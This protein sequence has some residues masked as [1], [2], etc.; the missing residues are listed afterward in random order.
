MFV[1]FIVPV[2][3]PDTEAF[4]KC[5]KGL[6]DQSFKEWEAIIVLDG[7]DSG[8]EAVLSCISDKRFN[9][10]RNEHKGAQRARNDGFNASKG[11][12]VWFWDADCLIEPDCAKTFVDEFKR[13]KEADFIYSGY[14]FMNEQGGIPSEAFDPWTLKCGNY[15]STCFPMR[16]EVFPGWDETLE[17]LQDWDLWLTVVERG[18]KGVFFPGYAFSTLMPTEHSISGKG[19]TN[20]V[21]KER[22]KAVKTKHN[23]PDRKVCVSSLDNRAEGIRL[24]KLIDADYKDVPNYKPNNYDTIIQ[25][26]FSLHPSRIKAHSSIFNQ[27]LKKKI[28]FWTANDI[29]GV[30]NGVSHRALREYSKALNCQVIQYVEDKYAKDIM[31]S[32]GFNVSIL[33]MPMVNTDAIEALPESP[34]LLLDYSQ[35]YQQL[36]SCLQHSLPDIKFVP[37]TENKPIKDYSA[38]L[39]LNSEKTM[40]FTIKRMLL[41]VRNVISNVQSPFCGYVGD[42]NDMG[43]YVSELVDTIRKRINKPANASVQ[44]WGK[45]LSADKLQEAISK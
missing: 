36:V 2:Y 40:S 4:K 23:I 34:T 11:E 1:S 41:A 31:N 38:L 20:D 27:P 30:N 39:S 35:E 25:V 37:I 19:C 26:G 7:P 9:V 21:W 24:A 42:N 3:K 15:I 13:N 44:F 22:V 5:L 29:I 32:A 43:K 17:S 33:P 14:R 28:I 12:I 8:A 18:G 16:R 45:E 6:K 10:I